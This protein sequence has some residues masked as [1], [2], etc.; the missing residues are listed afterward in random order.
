MR[1]QLQRELFKSLSNTTI[2]MFGNAGI[3]LK[4]THCRH[5]LASAISYWAYDLVIRDQVPVARIA[6][7]KSLVVEGLALNDL[8]RVYAFGPMIESIVKYCGIEPLQASALAAQICTML[9]N[10]GF[11]VDGREL[12]FNPALRSVQKKVATAIAS[13]RSLSKLMDPPAQASVAIMLGML[14]GAPNVTLNNQVTLLGRKRYGFGTL[15]ELVARRDVRVLMTSPDIDVDRTPAHM[16]VRDLVNQFDED[17]I[18]SAVMD[19]G[20]V[21]VAEAKPMFN[22]P[23][24]RKFEIFTPELSFSRQHRSVANNQSPGMF[25]PGY[26][27]VEVGKSNTSLTEEA[28]MPKSTG[29]SDLPQFLRCSKCMS[30]HAPAIPQWEHACTANKLPWSVVTSFVDSLRAA[31]VGTIQR[32]QFMRDLVIYIAEQDVPIPNQTVLEEWRVFIENNIFNLGMSGMSR[33]AVIDG[34][35]GREL[36]WIGRKGLTKAE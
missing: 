1:F 19:F 2:A 27:R 11:C 23:G 12:L 24:T 34:V 15:E 6:L 22:R 17:G 30:F 31:G 32:T 7:A 16:R 10:E 35:P 14:P 28:T 18:R 4:P 25:V 20:F 21:L 13:T 8:P 3:H 26:W 5:I 36:L 33:D 9:F 29:F